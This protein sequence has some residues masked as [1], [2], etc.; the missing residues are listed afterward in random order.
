MQPL[1][2]S[3]FFLIHR[4][5]SLYHPAQL[6]PV[7]WCLAVPHADVNVSLNV[8]RRKSGDGEEAPPFM[9]SGGINEVLHGEKCE[10]T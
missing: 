3:I 7:F 1:A 10:K 9:K 4:R 5:A 8:E 2:P 6:R